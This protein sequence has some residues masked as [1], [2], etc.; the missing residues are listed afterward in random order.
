M[1]EQLD[2]LMSPGA[3]LALACAIVGVL[4]L[5]SGLVALVRVKPLRF[6]IR[7]VL[8]LALLGFGAAMAAVAI[9]AYG[10]R[11]FTNEQFVA[12]IE[13][14]P[15]GPQRFDARFRFAGGREQSFALAGDEL[16]VDAHIL[17]WQPIAT[18]LG[19]RTVFELDRVSGRYRSIA[20]EEKGP[21]TLFALGTPKPFDLF[22]LRQRVAVLS[23][24]VDAEYGSASF[25]PAERA[26][27]LELSVS[28]SG[29]I[30]REKTGTAA[31]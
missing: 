11:A 8:G 4:L 15:T 28:T 21:R 7:A 20:D 23:R 17:K 24:F 18:A 22:T 25:A 5:A 13:I 27:E 30:L 6:T 31:K 26:T 12:R 19:L 10:Y 29:L 2:W 3:W 9:G 16:Y 14:Q 1:P